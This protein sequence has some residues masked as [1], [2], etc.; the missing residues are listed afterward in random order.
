MKRIALILCSATLIT[1]GCATP[2][3]TGEK[4]VDTKMAAAQIEP[5][6]GDERLSDTAVPTHYRLSLELDPAEETFSGTASITVELAEATDR[7]DLHAKDLDIERV[8][9]NVGKAKYEA[10]VVEGKNGGV[11]VALDEPIGPSKLQAKTALVFEYTAPLDEKP[12]GLYRVKDGDDWYAFTQFQPLSAREAFPSFDEP[13]FKTPFDVRITVPDGQKAFANTPT[14][15]VT[16]EGD[17]VVYDYAS[18]EPLPTYLVAFAAGP[19]EVLEA[20]KDAIPGVPLRVI[21][22]KGKSKLAKYA[23]DV[24]PALLKAQTDYFGMELPYAKIDMVA[25]PN[26]WAG[27]ME[28]V[29]LVTF[30][31]RL[32][33]VDPDNATPG[34]KYALQSVMAHE[35]AHMWFGNYVTPAWWND[36]WLNE[37]FAT[38]MATR[39]LAEVA[40]ELEPRIDAVKGSLRVMSADALAHARAIR[41]P[42]RDGGDVMNAFDGITY[43]KGRAVL[44]MFESWLGE[45]DFRDGVRAHLEANAHGNGTT[46]ELL[47]AWQEV[48]GKPVEQTIRQFLDQPGTPLVELDYKCEAGK[49]TVQLEQS[50]Y[51]PAGSTA[52]HGEP[53]HIPMCIKY[54]ADGKVVRTCEVLDAPKK[55]LTLAGDTCPAWIHPNA[56][57]AGYYHWKLPGDHFV[58]LAKDYRDAL[59]MPEKVALLPH[60]K[61]LV[62]AH[63]LAYGDYLKLVEHMAREDHR[64][65]VGQVIDALY[66]ID[67][68]AVDETN[69]AQFTA[70]AK[71]IIDP[72]VNRLGF[73]PKDGEP[74]EDGLLRPKVIRAAADLANDTK[75]IEQ[76]KGVAKEY[77]QDP[78]SVSIPQ[79]KLALR[80]AAWSGDEALWKKLRAAITKAPTP[81]ARVA[82]IGALGSFR[83]PELVK[84]SLELL[85]TDAIRSQDAWTLMGPTLGEPETREVAWSW[86]EQNYD[87]LVEKVG[88]KSATSLP[89]VGSA[90]CSKARK[91]QVEAF[92]SKEERKVKGMERNLGQALESI[93]RC[94]RYREY[95]AEDARAFLEDI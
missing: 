72:H 80:I 4:A 84:Q 75:V 54:E 12:H 33:L 66:G 51:L 48:S 50:R 77:L 5:F 9:V 17:R 15:S 59:S 18:T 19:L 42:I 90:F 85:L 46:K 7:I 10:K 61:A 36:I 35:F 70:W 8:W 37:A 32:L 38:W 13:R 3:E 16:E 1:T 23:L 29:G 2:P 86:L 41:Q 65:I 74:A 52:D 20:P 83:S 49:T 39:T 14:S 28:N 71:K 34:D 30:R 81:S 88:A 87:A 94:V 76:A 78:T 89:W 40:P 45:E 79:A 56:D 21:T 60:A 31:E 92:F 47:S 67:E 44:Q 55:T 6:D 24:A 73:A 57:E 11:T 82:T 58:A 93:D 64:V 27:A 25:V 22:T 26:F 43:T 68:H 63:G 91:D 69:R 62:E 95:M 53:W